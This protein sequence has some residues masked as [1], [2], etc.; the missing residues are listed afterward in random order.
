M[1]RQFEMKKI[2]KRTTIH[3]L[4]YMMLLT[5]LVILIMRLG[6]TENTSD[7]LIKQTSKYEKFLQ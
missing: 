2:F 3:I 5:L 4:I 7:K 6:A 1:E